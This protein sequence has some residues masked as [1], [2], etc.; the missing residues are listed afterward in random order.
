METTPSAPTRWTL[1]VRAQGSGPEARAALGELLHRCEQFVVWLIRHYRHPPDTT[2]EDLKQEFLAGVLRRNDIGKLDPARG[3]FRSWLGR[4]VRSFLY[5]EWDK[6]HAAAAG[7]GQTAA[8]LFEAFNRSTPEDEACLRA[9]AEHTLAR[10]LELQRAEAP[11]QQRFDVI[12]RFLPGP[13]MD[14]GALEPVA[15]SLDMKPTALAK[16][17]SLARSR[18]RKLLHAEIGDSVNLDE[19]RGASVEG[20]EAER[21]A[22]KRRA[23]EQELRELAQSL[24]ARDRTGVLLEPP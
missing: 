5:N 4:A 16:A 11:D 18:F 13:Q 7:R 12:A 1:I 9:F 6:W 2:P 22:A 19:D 10:V 3:S 23:V 15:R 14:I 20:S 17:I 21:Q 24:H 8:A